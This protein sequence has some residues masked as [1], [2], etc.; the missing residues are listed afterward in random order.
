MT[1]CWGT[2]NDGQCNVPFGLSNAMA[3]AGGQDFSLAMRGDGT[4]IGWGDNTYD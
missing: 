2:N 3:V 4:V 1:V